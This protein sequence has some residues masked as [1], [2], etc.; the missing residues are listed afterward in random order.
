MKRR[1]RRL[2]V[3][4]R[5]AVVGVAVAALLTG[6]SFSNPATVAT[7]Y[8]AS[9]GTHGE[10]KNAATGENVRLRNFLLV[11]AAQGGAGA[12][13]GAIANNGTRPVTVQL[14]VLD[15]TD[16]AQPQTVGR[17]SVEVAP[18][19][20]AQI[21]P[22]GTPFDLASIPA[23]PGE[24]LV[25]QAATGGG[26]TKFALPVLPPRDEYATVTSSATPAG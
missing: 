25:I 11:T 9:D 22:A 19:E 3:P 8:A 24:K 5:V 23:E 2:V 6:C 12:V 13:S 21:G 14:T 26:S 4:G 17:A 7:P 1:T 16:P 20:L 18:G 15:D 10:L